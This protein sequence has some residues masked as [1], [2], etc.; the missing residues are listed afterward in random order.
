MAIEYSIH[1]DMTGVKHY[2]V[3]YRAGDGSTRNEQ[4]SDL[5][6]RPMIRIDN[7]T[8]GKHYSSK[9]GQWLEH[10]LRTQRNS[11]KP[12]T[13]L[14]RRT[15][16]PVPPSDPRVAVFATVP[17]TLSFYEFRAPSGNVAIFCPELNM[18]MVWAK[19]RDGKVQETTRVTLG[20]PPDV[21]F[22]P[23]AAA[24]VIKRSQPAGT[25]SVDLLPS[26]RPKGRQ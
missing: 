23:P 1:D 6:S 12:F 24:R 20:I 22:A 26:Q 14:D 16:A 8:T 17:M 15:V 19:Y 11:G 18:R 10:P 9:E 25:G 4:V 21:A 2:V 13:A 5:D 7:L 3:E